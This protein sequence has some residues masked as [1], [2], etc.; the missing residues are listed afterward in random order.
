MKKSDDA[1]SFFDRTYN[2]YGQT[3]QIDR[4]NNDSIYCANTQSAVSKKTGRE[5]TNIKFT[6]ESSVVGCTITFIAI[7]MI[8]ANTIMLAR[9]RRTFINVL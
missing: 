7:H 3:E 1:I 5:F 4:Q 9:L 2:Y 8:N 6:D